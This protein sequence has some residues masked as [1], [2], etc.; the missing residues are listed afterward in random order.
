MSN[1]LMTRQKEL[2]VMLNANLQ[3]IESV[4]PANM[5]AKRFCRIAL[6]AVAKNPA[7]AECKPATFVLAVLN[8][9]ELG[10]EPI[11]G[12]VAL[13]PYNGYVT[14]QPMYQGLV[15]LARRSGQISTLYAEVVREG[16]EFEYELGL[17]PRLVHKPIGKGNLTH[18]YAVCKLKDGAVQFVVLNADEIAKVK[19]SSKAGASASSPWQTWTE[20]MWKKTAL[21]RLLKLLPKSTEMALAI[22]KDDKG[23]VGEKQL[24]SKIDLST[25]VNIPDD[26]LKGTS[27]GSGS[28]RKPE[29]PKPAVDVEADNELAPPVVNEDAEPPK[30]E[31]GRPAKRERY[32]EDDL[33]M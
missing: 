29:P 1:E 16:D 31:R 25:L 15:D 13:I 18:T 19:K 10:L 20:E 14:C 11:L 3:A 21:K 8:C 26:E 33:P 12:Q 23:E 6:N 28:L 9:A 2:G 30:R 24:P 32:V 7:L 5:N 22:E 4:L 17:N 27:E